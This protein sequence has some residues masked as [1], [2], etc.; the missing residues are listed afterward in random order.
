MVKSKDEKKVIFFTLNENDEIVKESLTE[1]DSMEFDRTR[2]YSYRDGAYITDMGHGWLL[3]EDRSL[4]RA[5]DIAPGV[6]GTVDENR[7]HSLTKYIEYS[8]S[9]SFSLS[10][11]QLAVQIAFGRALTE[12]L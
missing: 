6:T 10:Y 9:A 8:A 3:G 5:I 11:I 4:V 2:N 1:I 12:S 7:G